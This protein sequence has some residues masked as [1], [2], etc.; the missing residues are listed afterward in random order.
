MRQWLLAIVPAVVLVGIG[1]FVG[2]LIGGA[3]DS[4]AADEVSPTS[5][6]ASA[7]GNPAHG[8]ELWTAKSC[9]MCH[10]FGGS[11]GTDAPALDYMRGDLSIEGVAG[12]S[13]SIWNHLP[14]MLARFREEK[15]PY[16]SISPDEMADII[17]YLHGG[18]APAS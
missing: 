5:L 17:A 13:G 15:I 9:T 14:Q 6:P 18:Q 3:F 12:M 7:I 1:I 2:A 10:S 4:S 11:G 8:R 16:P